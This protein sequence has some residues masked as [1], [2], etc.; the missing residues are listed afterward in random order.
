MKRFLKT[1]K[2]TCTQIGVSIARV[3]KGIRFVNFH[4]IMHDHIQNSLVSE[5]SLMFMRNSLDKYVF[6]DWTRHIAG[7]VQVGSKSCRVPRVWGLI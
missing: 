6:R 7:T 5:V 1:R 2:W 3:V 4:P